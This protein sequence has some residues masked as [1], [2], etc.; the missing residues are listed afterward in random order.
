M[1]RRRSL[2]FSVPHSAISAS[3]R[4]QP[5][6]SPDRGSMVQTLVQGEEIGI[7]CVGCDVRAT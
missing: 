5:R 4:P 7:G 2:S 3:V 6:H 1:I